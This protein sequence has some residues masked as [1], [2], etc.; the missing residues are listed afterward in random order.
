MS[1]DTLNLVDLE[2]LR[3]LPTT[4]GALL[5]LRTLAP[6]RKFKAYNTL[7][8]ALEVISRNK[9]VNR[10]DLLERLS[11]CWAWLESRGL[12]GPSLNQDGWQRVTSRGRALA[13]SDSAL[14]AIIAEDQ[15]AMTLHPKLQPNVRQ[16]FALGD[17]ETAV[18]SAM[19]AVEI[20]VR[21]LS[22]AS[23][24][25]VGVKLM[26]TAFNECGPLRDEEA[27]VGEQVATANLFAGA[28]GTFKNP[29]S[30]RT[31][32]YADPTEAAEIVLLADLLMRHLDRVEDRLGKAAAR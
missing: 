20:R 5:L 27:D 12:L 11:D 4:D 22:Q 30:H 25:V 2:Q 18:F 24:S 10:H 21:D 23:D 31:V 7:G 3:D 28:I 6:K 19:K 15:L 1:R 14:N 26:R 29:S 8:D 17:Y 13:K 9:E 32:S 16:I